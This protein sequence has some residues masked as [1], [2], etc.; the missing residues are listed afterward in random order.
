MSNLVLYSYWRSSCSYRVRVALNFKG[1]D[2][3][4]RDVHLVRDGGE[5]HQEAYRKLNPMG[6]VPSLITPDGALTQSMAILEYLELV[7]PEPSLFPGNPYQ[8]CRIRAVCET[9]NAGIQPLQNLNVLQ[10]LKTRYGVDQDGVAEWVAHWIAK[11]LDAVEKEVAPHAGRFCFGDQVTAADM[12]LAPQVY[13][14]VRFKVDMA[15]FPTLS[16][17]N[18][19]CLKEPVF[20]DAE[21]SRQPDAAPA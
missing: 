10:D 17:I 8:A 15:Q 21:P 14:A 19:A 1:L 2:Y 5:Q 16:R 11:G 6:Q 4:Y 20:Q 7:K 3:E 13:N 9:I 18:G 12:F